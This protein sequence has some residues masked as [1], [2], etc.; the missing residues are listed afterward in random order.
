MIRGLGGNLSLSDRNAFAKEVKVHIH[1]RRLI[2]CRSRTGYNTLV[3]CVCLT[4][5]QQAYSKPLPCNHPP[6]IAHA[7]E[8]SKTCFCTYAA[9]QVFQWAGERPPDISCPLDCYSDRGALTSYPAVPPN[10]GLDAADGGGIGIGPQ[11]VVPTVS[12]QVG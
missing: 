4:I 5:A 2:T 3:P 8:C 7:I 10:G 12:V 1:H 9:S 11:S 6:C